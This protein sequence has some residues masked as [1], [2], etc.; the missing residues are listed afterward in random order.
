MHRRPLSIEGLENRDL[1]ATLQVDDD[2]ADCKKADFTSIQAAV[3]AAQPGD[4]IQVCE[5]TYIEQVTIPG[6]KDGL[7][8]RSKKK[9][10]AVI[11][12]PPGMTEPGIVH[13]NGADD[14][15]IRGFTIKGP[16]TDLSGLRTG[17]F[18]GG[19]GSASIEENHI[20]EIRAEPLNGVQNGVGIL[21]GRGSTGES[22]SATIERNLID[23]YQKGGIVVD[24]T[25]SSAAIHDNDIVGAGPTSVIV[26]NGIQI[27]NGASADIRKN[28]ITGNDFIGPVAAVG[29]LLFNPDEVSA[30][31]NKVTENGVGVYVIN[32]EDMELKHNDIFDSSNVGIIL[33]SVTES[34][35]AHNK[36]KNSG[37][38]GISMVNSHDNDLRH[39]KVENSAGHG[40]SLDNSDN[41]RIDHNQS[42]NNS[43]D[44]LHVTNDSAGNQITHNKMRDNGGFDCYDD[45]LGGGTA[46][47]DNFWEENSGET[48]NRD[49]LCD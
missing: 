15:T 16:F 1:L 33:D 39:N 28:S 17:I 21:V 19:G 31:H 35:L 18:V 2:L 36:I 32:A 27:S 45:T 47:T 3:K 6:T 26:Q 10:A 44:G 43:G 23:D 37:A 22:G 14:V 41:N 7:E 9:L 20:T 25:G 12:A 13:V 49:G 4:E 42:K 34:L 30:A 8:L 40:I 46:G 48:E 5:G 38:D 11:Q 29:V 24:N